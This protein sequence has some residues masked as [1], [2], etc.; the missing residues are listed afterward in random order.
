MFD[1]R[2][3]NIATAP[4]PTPAPAPAT[5][6]ETSAFLHVTG[7]ETG[8]NHHAALLFTEDE[9]GSWFVEA[10]PTEESHDGLLHLPAG[11]IAGD[12]LA[13]LLGLVM[14]LP[15]GPARP[16]LRPEPE[17]GI[18]VG[19]VLEGFAVAFL[20]PEGGGERIRVAG[21]V[22]AVRNNGAW[23]IV[24]L[25]ELRASLEEGFGMVATPVPA[26]GLDAPAG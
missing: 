24:P 3:V 5:V 17:P 15:I 2:A 16:E 4:V 14:D 8:W 13:G 6:R 21:P 10:N 25:A 18:E 19:P 11:A 1:R 23:T 20:H 26:L 22:T 7:P 12:A 9:A